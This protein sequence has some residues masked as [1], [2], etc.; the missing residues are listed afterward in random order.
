M[1]AGPLLT[2]LAVLST[3]GLVACDPPLSQDELRS[4]FATG[5][6]PNWLFVQGG[7]I[8][9]DDNSAAQIREW[10]AS[11]EA[12]WAPA[13]LNDFD[14]NK[15]QLL[16]SNSAVEIDGNRML[17]SFERKAD[18]TDTTIYI[19]RPLSSDERLF[20]DSIVERIKEH[21]RPR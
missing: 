17:V 16:T 12:G 1:R 13:S 5:R 2:S 6:G 14:P 20:W 7:H 9:F 18:D 19:Q 15:T 11:H 10:L 8:E 21:N 4:H 3:C